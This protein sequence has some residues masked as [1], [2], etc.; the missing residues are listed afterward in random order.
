MATTGL[1]PSS[2]GTG[3]TSASSGQSPG[4]D[5]AC[6]MREQGT[7][8][9]NTR[10]FFWKNKPHPHLGSGGSNSRAG[11]EDEPYRTRMDEFDWIGLD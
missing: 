5:S 8:R 4:P 10:F 11:E 7:V 1:G 9:S 3:T 2:C 6:S